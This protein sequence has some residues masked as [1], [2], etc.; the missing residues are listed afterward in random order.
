MVLR[1][2]VALCPRIIARAEITHSEIAWGARGASPTCVPQGGERGGARGGEGGGRGRW[3]RTLQE[4]PMATLRAAYGAHGWMLPVRVCSR[5]PCPPAARRLSFLHVVCPQSKDGGLPSVLSVVRDGY[6]HGT[7][8]LPCPHADQ[9]QGFAAQPFAQGGACPP[10]Q[11]TDT[12]T[13]Q[14]RGDPSLERKCA[15]TEG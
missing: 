1:G 10:S 6:C 3:L 9:L 2:A 13:S 8:T 5:R 14:H 11:D 7:S 4:N 12:T 15:F